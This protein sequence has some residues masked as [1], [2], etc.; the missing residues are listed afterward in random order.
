MV[1]II[2]KPILISSETGQGYIFSKTRKDSGLVNMGGLIKV[3]V[4]LGHRQSRRLDISRYPSPYMVLEDL[5]VGVPLGHV[6]VLARSYLAGLLAPGPQAYRPVGV[7]GPIRTL[8]LSLLVV[9][10]VFTITSYR[11]ENLNRFPASILPFDDPSAVMP[12]LSGG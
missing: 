9:R 4:A 1:S 10:F 11:L 7:L 6:A 12:M 5:G 8:C 3:V 2:D